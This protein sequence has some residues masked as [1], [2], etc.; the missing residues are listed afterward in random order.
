MSEYKYLEEF[1][2]DAL[3]DSKNIIIQEF[4]VNKDFVCIYIVTKERN[5]FDV[6]TAVT[7]INKPVDKDRINHVLLFESQIKK[8]FKQLK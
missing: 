1:Y 4:D 8:L 3:I 5:M 7:D 2:H 6:F